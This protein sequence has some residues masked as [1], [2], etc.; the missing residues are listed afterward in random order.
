MQ[1]LQLIPWHPGG[2]EVDAMLTVHLC[3]HLLDVL[4]LPIRQHVNEADKEM[5]RCDTLSDSWQLSGPRT[6]S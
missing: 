3:K 4:R 5:D 1:L 2:E 6:Q